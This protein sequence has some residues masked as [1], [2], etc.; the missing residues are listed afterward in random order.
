VFEYDRHSALV[1]HRIAMSGLAERMRPNY[2]PALR[3]SDPIADADAVASMNDH[4]AGLCIAYGVKLE[5]IDRNGF[6]R[7]GVMSRLERPARLPRT[8]PAAA[9]PVVPPRTHNGRRPVV[10]VHLPADEEPADGLWTRAALLG[11]EQA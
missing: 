5:D 3:H 11:G 10:D 6:S 8:T 7:P 9:S 1:H 4:R 2:G